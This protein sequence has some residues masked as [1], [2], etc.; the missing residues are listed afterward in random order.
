[1][2]ENNKQTN[3]NIKS[4]GIW[5]SII[6]AIVMVV[7]IILNLLN[8]DFEFKLVIEIFSYV[9]AILVSIGVLNSKL[10]GKSVEEIKQSIEN[11]INNNIE[12]DEDNK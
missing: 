2:E 1:M 7:Q 9:L 8:I 10:K 12:I 6:C 3:L 4:L 5:V 11:E